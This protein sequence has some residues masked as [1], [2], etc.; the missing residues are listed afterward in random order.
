MPEKDTDHFA[1]GRD[2]D[3]LF[4]TT[5]PVTL[6]PLRHINDKSIL[7]VEQICTFTDPSP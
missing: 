6:E 4:Y 5:P 1:S 7:S 2:H 3:V